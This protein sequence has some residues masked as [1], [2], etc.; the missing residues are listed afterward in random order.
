MELNNESF[1]EGQ[2]HLFSLYMTKE[3][4]R[5]KLKA[6][7]SLLEFDKENVDLNGIW[8]LKQENTPQI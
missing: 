4:E 5:G 1:E 8:S 3:V 2:R 7:I 6:N